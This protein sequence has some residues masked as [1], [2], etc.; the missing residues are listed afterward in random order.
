MF[1]LS[2]GVGV[3]GKDLAFKIKLEGI[4]LLEVAIEFTVTAHFHSNRT[5]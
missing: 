3:G 1:V 4:L 5:H 2:W